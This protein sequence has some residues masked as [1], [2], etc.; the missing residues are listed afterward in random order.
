MKLYINEDSLDDR[1]RDRTFKI[2]DVPEDYLYDVVEYAETIGLEKEQFDYDDNTET[3]IIKYSPYDNLGFE[4]C[5]QVYNW[6]Q[7]MV[8]LTGQG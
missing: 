6:V 8:Y 5:S 7:D 2:P 1:L 4:K 3:V